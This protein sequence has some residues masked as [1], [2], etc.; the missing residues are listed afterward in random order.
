MR[1]LALKEERHEQIL[2]ILKQHKFIKVKQLTELLNVSEMTI[3]R[4]LGTLKKKGVIHRAHGGAVANNSEVLFEPYFKRRAFHSFDKKDLIGRTAVQFVNTGDVLGVGVGTTTQAFATYLQPNSASLVVTNWIPLVR[5]LSEKKGIPVYLIGGM[6]RPEENSLVGEQAKRIL[7]EYKIDA[8]FF[9]CSA[10]NIKNGLMDYDLGESE[11]MRAFITYAEKSYL[12][13]DSSKFGRNA[14]TILSPLDNVD[15]IITDCS[16]P[17]E[18][19]EYIQFQ[20]KELIIA[21]K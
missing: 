10:F 9:S 4:D 13:I 5:E 12:L 18:Y 20:N 2:Q 8:Y 14:P 11:L 15:A 3:R 21:A 1:I 16:I 19:K 17:D 6:V 7:S